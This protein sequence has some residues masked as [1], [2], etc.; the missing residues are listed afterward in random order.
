MKMYGWVG[1]LLLVISE[2]G[3]IRKIEPFTTWFYCF[4]WWSYILLADNLLLK[5]RGRSL[6]T[7]RRRELWAML[8]LSVCIWLLFEAYNLVLHNWS[9]SITPMPAWQRWIGYTLSFA[10]VLPG[11]FI[12]SDLVEAF[13]GRTERPAASE[14]EAGAPSIKSRFFAFSITAGLALS[15]A[16]V[17]WP[18]YF[19]AAVWIGPVLLLDP[20][21]GKFGIRSLLS[22][23][24]SRNDRRFWSLMLGGLL[25]GLMWEFWNFWAGSKWSY[26]IPFFDRWKIFEMPVLG[27]LGFPPFAL[28]C[29]ILYHLL[30]AIPKHMGSQAARVAWWVCLGILSL[31]ILRGI[32]HWTLNQVADTA[33]KQFF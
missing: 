28:E 20:L 4:A 22:G 5:L 2:Y 14:F 26:S 25:C 1:L 21:L 11:V 19:F 9:Y 29:W 13:W 16:P 17:I 32:D 12:T 8:P 6:L 18:R 24:I 10:T 33:A 23:G 27:F 7:N 3:L 31:I 30:R 15:I